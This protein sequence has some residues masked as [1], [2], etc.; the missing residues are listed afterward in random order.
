[1]TYPQGGLTEHRQNLKDN[2]NVFAEDKQRAI[3][4]W[5]NHCWSYV[6]QHGK[7]TK[8]QATPI[9][10]HMAEMVW[11]AQNGQPLFQFDA[12]SSGLPM[13]WNRP[14]DGELNY[15]RYEIGHIHPQL[16]GGESNPE[17][18]TFQSARCNQHIQSSL[19]IDEVMEY[20]DNISP[21]QVRMNKLNEL[22]HSDE[23][24]E[25]KALVT[26]K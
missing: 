4:N 25:L 23:W 5:A 17:N 24:I 19:D 7:L 22:H 11:E 13:S 26:N 15:I 14:Q 1:M 2:N 20:F 3:T 18:L 6:K 8:K 21:V 16:E 9:L 12:P 10:Q